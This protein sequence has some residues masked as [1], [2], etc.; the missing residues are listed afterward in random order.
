MPLENEDFEETPNDLTRTKTDYAVREVD[1][2][3]GVRGG[4]LSSGT[5]KLKT[6]PADPTGPVSTATGWFK[7]LLGGKTKEKHKGFEVVRSARAPPPGLF[8]PP[9]PIPEGLSSEPY[10]DDVQAEE[11]HANRNAPRVASPI[12]QRQVQRQSQNQSVYDDIPLDDSDDGEE[13]ISPVSTVPVRPPSLPLIESVG[14]IE[15]PSRIGSEASRKSRGKKAKTQDTDVPAVPAIPRKSSRRQSGGGSQDRGM[16]RAALYPPGPVK[17]DKGSYQTSNAN[18]I[19]F[20][21]SQRSP[22]RAK[23]YS[24]GAESASSSVIRDGDENVPIQHH[25]YTGQLRQSASSAL[26]SHGADWRHDRPSNMG[27]V[28]QHRASD[29]IH[30]SPDSAE[31]EGSA[32]EIHGRPQY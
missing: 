2:Y 31:I 16:A 30:Y 6:G 22:V 23:R 29:N 21:S 7:N 11:S 13:P 32:A 26:G 5:R 20:T 17:H 19:P 27:F 9:T 3:Y 28:Q 10:H 15:L 1:F 8:P 25:S 4:A 14:G 12:S 18:R 24:T